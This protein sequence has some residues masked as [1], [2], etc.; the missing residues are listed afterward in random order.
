MD[1]IASL[2]PGNID[3]QIITFSKV[4]WMPDL[5]EGGNSEILEKVSYQAGI[6]QG[7]RVKFVHLC[8]YDVDNYAIY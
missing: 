7:V 1:A 8:T 4:W 5:G 6:S 3:K 2:T